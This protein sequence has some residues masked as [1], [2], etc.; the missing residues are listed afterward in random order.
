MLE[1]ASA[2]VVYCALVAAVFF[3]LWLYYDRRDHA[4]FEVE[5]RK[6]TFHCIR[7][8][9]LYTAPIG[10]ELAPCPRCAHGNTRL[11]F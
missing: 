3:G 4:R 5:R 8:D 2:V 1:L 9:A 11:K 7:C 6:A 10:P